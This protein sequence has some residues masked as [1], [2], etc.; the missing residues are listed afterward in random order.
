M[1]KAQTLEAITKS[2]EVHELQMQ[3][4]ERAMNGTAIENPTAVNKTECD[5]GKW[6]YA[7]DNHMQEI[8]GSQFYTAL[9][10]QHEKWH[11]EYRKIHT[12][13]FASKSKKGLFSKLLGSSKIDPLEL[14]KAKLYYS[15]LQ[16]TTSMLLKAL[17]SSQRRV[18]ALPDSKFH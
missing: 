1:T 2:K 13:L 3:K 17:A 15:D 9:D 8:L 5:F 18:S 11:N 14:D 10:I 16:E 7:E 12:I 4:I 6:L